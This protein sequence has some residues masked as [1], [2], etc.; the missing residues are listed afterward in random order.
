MEITYDI[1][2]IR[3][4]RANPDIRNVAP[5]QNQIDIHPGTLIFPKDS[6]QINIQPRFDE[7]YEL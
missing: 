5:I 2:S 3:I 7:I 4:E 6:F 1:K